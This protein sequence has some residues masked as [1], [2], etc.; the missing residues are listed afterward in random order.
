MQL[1]ELIKNRYIDSAELVKQCFDIFKRKMKSHPSATMLIL[2]KT[3]S[4]DGSKTES[5]VKLNF[6]YFVTLAIGLFIL[7]SLFKPKIVTHNQASL[8]HR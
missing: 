6:P 2:L 7:D 1:L 3:L 4:T 5:S 8:S